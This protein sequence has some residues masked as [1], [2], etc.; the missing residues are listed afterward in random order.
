V[1]VSVTNT[2]ERRGVAVPQL[3]LGLPSRPAAVQP[4]KALK[5]FRRVALA[6]DQSRRVGFTLDRRA[7]SYWDVDRHGWRLARGCV[8]ILVGRSSRHLPL[9]ATLAVHAHCT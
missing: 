9:Q 4:P 3:Y 2:G 6:P 8:R 7:L 5:G 1:S